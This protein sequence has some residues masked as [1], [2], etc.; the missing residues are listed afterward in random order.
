MWSPGRGGREDRPKSLHP[1]LSP[2]AFTIRVE[3]TSCHIRTFSHTWS[4]PQKNASRFFMT[5][6]FGA[7]C[8]RTSAES[9][10]ISRVTHFTSMV[11]PT[12]FTCLLHYLQPYRLRTS[13]ARRNRIRRAGSTKRGPNRSSGGRSSTRP[14]ALANPMPSA[15]GI[16]SRN[17]RP[18]TDELHFRM[19]QWRCCENT[20]SSL[21]NG[22]CGSDVACLF[23]NLCRPFRGFT[24]VF[25]ASQTQ[26]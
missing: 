8:M 15:F 20:T 19:S 25:T 22:I 10:A 11:S 14:S 1:N 16:T 7:M 18:I 3:V 17:R 23:E 4:S 21:M 13:C 5:S 6:S 12:T 26:G 2:F 24:P 9:C